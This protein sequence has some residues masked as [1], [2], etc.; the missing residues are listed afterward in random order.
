LTPAAACSSS[1]KDDVNQGRAK[2]ETEVVILSERFRALHR[3]L[4][5]LAAVLASFLTCIGASAR[6]QPGKIDVLLVGSSGT[7]SASADPGKEKAA[8]ETLQSFIKEETGLKNDIVRQKNWGDLAEKMSK[9]QLHLGV[10]QGY[11]FA[12]AKEKYPNLRPLA[13][14]VNVYRYPVAY[15]VT[16]KDSPVKSFADLQGKILAMPAGTG[17]VLRL[18]VRRQAQAVGKK[19]DTFFS[20][21]KAEENIEDALD[22]VVDGAVQ[23]AVADRA[24]LEAF[25]RRKPGRFKQLKPVA[26]SQP[27]PAPVVAYY[28]KVLD[29]DTLRRFQKGLVGASGKERGQTTLTLFRLTGF[30]TVP[31]DY[32]RVLAEAR[33]TYP[34]ETPKE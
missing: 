10:F 4:A 6:D 15:V 1:G 8:L 22:D 27:F 16:R 13:I 11:E 31:N 23:A 3:G 25:K 17:Q 7:I 20:K 19:T 24:A 9:G 2:G 34:P 12:W 18:Y 21:I 5:V 29:D 14:A 26:Q 30:E 28:D 32:D 33:K